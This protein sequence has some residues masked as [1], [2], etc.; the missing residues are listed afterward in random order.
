MTRGLLRSCLLFCAACAGTPGAPVF[1]RLGFDDLAPGD[2]PD[3]FVVD[4]T[5]GGGPLAT[6]SVAR[7]GDAPSAPNVLSLIRVE[8]GRGDTFNLC[9]NP[10]IP[11]GDGEI[12]LR[13]RATGGE[14]DQGG[15][16]IWRALDRDHY[17]V[18]RL[19]PLE[20]N[21]RLYFVEGGTGR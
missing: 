11:F 17:Y 8:H 1:L 3:G 5:R 20:G 12:S 21:L 4:A 2:L 10:G 19:N 7:A 9:W 15:G 6:W 14:E 18:T 13:L 16:V